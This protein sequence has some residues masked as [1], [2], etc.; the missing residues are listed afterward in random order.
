VAFGWIFAGHQIG[1]AFGA[2]GAG[3]VR[4]STATYTLA[5]L[6]AGGICLVAALLVLRI[7]RF[8]SA[9]GTVAAEPG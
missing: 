2:L 8:R 4:T 1:A 3:I 7:A 9:V 5:F 6:G